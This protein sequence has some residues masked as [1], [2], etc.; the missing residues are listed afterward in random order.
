MEG[1]EGIWFNRR[2]L[3]TRVSH[4]SSSRIGH[5]K[6]ACSKLSSELTDMAGS[7]SLITIFGPCK[8][9]E[10]APSIYSGV[11]LTSSESSELLLV[12][13]DPSERTVALDELLGII[14]IS[15]KSS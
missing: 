7:G 5:T 6:E 14:M 9:T 1:F 3:S 10:L 8:S 13:S 2:C 11:S 4:E 15:S 12:L